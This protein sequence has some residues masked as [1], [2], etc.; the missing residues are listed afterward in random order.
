MLHDGWSKNM[1]WKILFE[2]IFLI[3]AYA[4]GHLA[5]AIFRANTR[6]KLL[7]LFFSS[8]C[9]S[10]IYAFFF[11]QFK[12]PYLEI[13]YGL[14]AVS[15]I[16]AARVREP[17]EIY[18]YKYLYSILI[19]IFSFALFIDEYKVTPATGYNVPQLVGLEDG[20]GLIVGKGGQ[21]VFFNHHVISKRQKDAVD[22]G[23]KIGYQEMLGLFT[24]HVEYFS[25]FGKPVLSPCSGE[26][27]SANFSLPDQQPG[28]TIESTPEGNS[29]EINCTSTTGR[30]YIFRFAHLM[31]ASAKLAVHDRLAQGQAIGRIGNTGNTSWP[32][33]HVDIIDKETEKPVPIFIQGQY[34]RNG[35][36]IPWTGRGT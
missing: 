26:I 20:E 3:P 28:K 31:Q 6:N 16:K 19:L 13:Y 9:S 4:I 10:M 15:L 22:I 1:V 11:A 8:I 14:S 29:V 34:L 17:G 12:Y 7:Y 18:R 27:V 35:D 30:S 33:L 24:G 25:I 32:H 23:M 36:A 21:T 2:L 5:W